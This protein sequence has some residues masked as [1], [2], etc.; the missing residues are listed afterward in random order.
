[1]RRNQAETASRNQHPHQFAPSWLSI[2][3]CSTLFKSKTASLDSFDA[4]TEKLFWQE[5]HTETVTTSKAALL[6]GAAA[7][8]AFVILDV[9]TKGG[10]SP[11][12]FIGRCLIVLVLC[13]LFSHLH[14]HQQAHTQITRVVKLS[15]SISVIN[16]I[17]VMLIDG[18]PAFYIET[19]PGLLPIYFFTYGQMVLPIF[20]TIVFGWLSSFALPLAGYL[21]GTE[22]VTLIPSL[23]ILSIVNLFGLCTRCQ[24]EVHSRNSFRERRKA[25]YAAK[26]K[27]LFLRQISHNLRQPLQAMSCY[28][29]VLEAAYTEKPN[30]PQKPIV[31]KLCSAIDELNNA[32]N[33][34]LD[35][36][37]LE[38]GKQIP[39]LTIFDINVLL[40]SLEDQFAPQ[41]AKRG[42]K[43]KVRLRAKRPYTV[44]SDPYILTQIISNLIDNAIKYTNNGWVLIGT[45]KLSNNQLKLHIR[46]TGIGFSEL[47]KHSIFKEFYRGH[48]RSDDPQTSGLGIGLAYVLTA[49]EHLPNHELSVYSTPN[50]G[51]DFQLYLPI[52]IE[53]P[54]CKWTPNKNNTVFGSFVLIVD[55]DHNVLD[56]LADQLCAWGCLVQKANSKAE[57]LTVLGEI[58]RPPDL[59]ITDFFLE[60]NE[61]AHDIIAAIQADC[62][63]VPTIILSAQAISP[64]E[65]AKWPKSTLLLRKPAN[66]AVLMEMMAKA[67]GK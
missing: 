32:F 15:V 39:L 62:G 12:E 33:H 42:L 37:N 9:T 49:V 61:T 30:D 25:E 17:A 47:Q 41:A 18:D 52:A 59:L 24:L 65:K 48:R 21:M 29:S 4:D 27:S 19:W 36:A 14:Y 6:L 55:D 60:N 23:L 58:I 22:I 53:P 35:I 3:K 11:V 2:K 5:L 16:L 44:Y 28:S 66:A 45:V 63:P 57:T 67:M 26:D 43:L 40:A 8:L 56:A 7:F 50:R 1:M 31:G 20:D 13:E 54:Y 46:D 64:E 38:T 34:V 10:L 51:S